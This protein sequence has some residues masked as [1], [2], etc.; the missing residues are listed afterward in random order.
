MGPDGPWRVARETPALERLPVF[1]RPGTIL[2]RQPLVQS[3]AETPDGPL[4][5]DFG[6]LEA[7]AASQRAG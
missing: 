3:T 6:S 4:S 5:V 7:L 1:V 2:P